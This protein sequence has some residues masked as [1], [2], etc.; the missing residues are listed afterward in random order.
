MPPVREDGTETGISPQKIVD[1]NV[2][3]T[4][5]KLLKNEGIELTDLSAEDFSPPA[6][7][8]RILASVRQA[9]GQFRQSR[10]DSDDGEFLA[11]IRE[12]LEQGFAEAR[13][14][15]QN[16]GVLQGRIADD[17]DQTYDLTMQGLESMGE[18]GL[19]AVTA[20]AFQGVSLQTSQAVQMQIETQEGDLVTL[21]F[22]QSA[23]VSETALQ[24]SQPGRIMS[25]Y[26]Q[27]AMVS[28]ELNIVI[29]GDLNTDE[30]KAIRKV[31]QNM[32]KI[33]N[34]FFRGNGN[35]ALKHAL[36][37]G[38]DSE[39]I[40]GFSLDLSLQR[41]LQAVAA[42]RQTAQP[43]Q[44]IDTGLLAQAGDFLS[45]AQMLLAGAEDGLL[46]LMEP[47]Q[48]FNDLFTEIGLLNAETM[49]EQGATADGQLF[50]DLIDMLS[51]NVF[52]DHFEQEAA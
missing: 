49:P 15:L 19:D 11:Q 32:H 43:E 27:S 4:L 30:Q 5:G 45:G 36:K 31:M 23:S 6:V 44:N 35:A 22:A 18:G 33:S 14:I 37:A 13:D 38:F 10:P 28:S 46:R 41:S 21:S 52:G 12:G 51:Q 7:S 25:A 34:A 26:Q 16:L 8:D 47:K 20:M 48:A 40:A 2:V 17:V 3:D 42:Y 24:A 29:E 9:Y 50:A 39:Q 1:L